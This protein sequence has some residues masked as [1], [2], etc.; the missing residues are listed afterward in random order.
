VRSGILAVTAAVATLALGAGT[1]SAAELLSTSVTAAQAVDRTCASEALSG[2]SGYAQKSVTMPALGSITARLDG[3]G[4]G[5]W[6]L[7]VFDADSGRVVAGAASRGVLEVATGFAAAGDELTVQAC[8]LSGGPASV[9]LTVSAAELD[10]S[11]AQ[12]ASLVKVS[13]PTRAR[14]QALADLGL[15]LTEHGGPGFAEVVLHGAED[16]RELAAHGFIYT[17]EIPDLAAQSAADRRADAEYARANVRSEL[18]SGRTSYRRLFD[19]EGDLKRLA[20]EHPDLVRPI[21]LPYRSFEG[22]SVEGI[23]ITTSPNARDGKPVFLQ[24]GVHHARE[25][26]SAEHA[27][28]WA[29]VAGH[30][31]RAP[32]PAAPAQPP[33]KPGRATAR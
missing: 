32:G 31:R 18:P 1:A 26:P 21:T 3:A 27:M 14:A 22:R 10:M 20:R 17:V 30:T 29:Y 9:Q 19:Y 5:D 4:S 12:T 2:G 33:T 8:R 15:D 28:E 7:A 13:T 6:D 16:A 23:E 24:M 25:W 11:K